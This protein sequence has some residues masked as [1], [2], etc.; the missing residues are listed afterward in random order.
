M[1]RT[2][3]FAVRLTAILVDNPARC[4]HSEARQ[5]LRRDCRLRARGRVTEH[6]NK[7]PRHSSALRS[8][9]EGCVVLVRKIQRPRVNPVY[10]HRVSGPIIAIIILSLQV[11]VQNN[12]SDHCSKDT[13]LVFH[14]LA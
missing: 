7:G 8:A 10:P 4:T 6:W 12:V 13:Q 1:S 5:R 2:C 9:Q 14:E 11:E 3:L